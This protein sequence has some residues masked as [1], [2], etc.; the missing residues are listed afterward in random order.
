ETDNDINIQIKRQTAIEFDFNITP[1][2]LIVPTKDIAEIDVLFKSPDKFIGQIA[3]TLDFTIDNKLNLNGVIRLRAQIVKVDLEIGSGAIK[4]E[5][6]DKE[7]WEV[8]FSHVP[9]GST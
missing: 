9:C 5:Q 4:C 2:Q 6:N 1:D 3:E 7:F 8:D